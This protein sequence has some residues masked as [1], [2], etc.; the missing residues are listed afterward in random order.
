MNRLTDS[1]SIDVLEV[2]E[3]RS[4]SAS[5]D[6]GEFHGF[7]ENDDN[8]GL[9]TI[10]R[11]LQTVESYEHQAIQQPETI[12]SHSSS[13]PIFSPDIANINY[14]ADNSY[15]ISSPETNMEN[16]EDDTF[17]VC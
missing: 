1:C 7:A 17:E 16:S 3:Q 9:N 12:S 5:D 8:T 2:A 14:L 4:L 11:Y 10:R 6:S 15:R 13:V